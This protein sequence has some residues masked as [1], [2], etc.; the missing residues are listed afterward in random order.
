MA[1][2]VGINMLGQWLSPRSAARS[3]FVL[4]LAPRLVDIAGRGRLLADFHLDFRSQTCLRTNLGTKHALEAL[5]LGQV[6]EIVSDNLSAV[7]TIPFMLDGQGC[8]HLGTVHVGGVWK[9]YA[10]RHRA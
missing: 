9:I 2:Q 5:V 1:R 3:C 8:E 7:E 4:K 10:R 6:L